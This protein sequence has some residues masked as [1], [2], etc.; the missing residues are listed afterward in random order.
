[1]RI[2]FR[3]NNYIVNIFVEQSI[4]NSI[5]FYIKIICIV[6]NFYNIITILIRYLLLF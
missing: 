6:F 1:M 5:T 4:K 2:L 3:F